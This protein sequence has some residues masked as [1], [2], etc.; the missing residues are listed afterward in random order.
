MK[1]CI[2]SL[3][4]L[5]LA[6]ALA[7]SGARAEVRLPGVFSDHM[8][9]QRD[10]AVPLWGTAA[11]GEEVTVAFAGQSKKAKADP[12]GKWK[13][14]LDPMPASA[15]PRELTVSGAAGSPAVKIED[16]LVGEVWVGSGQSNM[17]MGVG[18]YSEHDPVLAANMAA[19]PYPK[20]RLLRGG[21]APRWVES[22]P[23]NIKGF[24]AMLFSFGL[25][26]HKALD[27]PVGLMVGAVGGTPSGYWLSEA[28]LQ[29]D[30][31]CQDLIKKYAATYDPTQAQKKYEADLAKW[32]NDVAVAKE[33]KER[34]PR[35]PNPPVNPGETTGG[36][37]GH[38]YET[39]IRPLVGYGIRGVL[40]DQ[41]ESGTALPGVDQYTLMG[42]LI[43]GWRAEWALPAAADASKPGRDFA[44]LYIEKPSGGGCAWDPANPVTS[45][46]EAFSPLP[47]AVP[48]DGGF[49]E[50]H[51][52]IMEYPNT[53]MA[54]S[55]D[56]GPNTH[57]VCKSGYGCRAAAVAQGFVYGRKVEYYGPLYA[58]HKVEGGKV[59]V[60]FTHV[61]KGLA[62]RNGEKLQGFAVAGED[63]AF[64]WAD[65]AIEGDAV[66]LSCAAVP[67]PAFIRYAWANKRT[68]ANLFNQ[69]GL[70]AVPFRTDR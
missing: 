63:K 32:T 5:A 1:R 35:K 31:P 11:P 27:V 58:S 55:S 40:W 45:Q 60:S 24:S 59:R 38:L 53:A 25:P 66:V 70:P 68:W 44:F 6:L 62:F 50:T 51:V 61:G 13:L 9:L 37:V 3:A 18:S 52:R 41:G 29:A 28:A 4:V 22:T 49:V 19:G 15:D 33:K 67:K 14:A 30:A 65:A 7:A 42:G 23:G 36:Q 39:F 64:H 43:R 34:E 26:L 12:D 48:N 20:L 54:I 17:D 57:P 47:A 69:D 8:V 10:L 46:A 21:P 56:L 2:G 16:V